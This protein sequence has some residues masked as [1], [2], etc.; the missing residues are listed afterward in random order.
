MPETPDP[1]F[2]LFVI[3]REKTELEH[4]MRSRIQGM[5]DSGMI[6][7]ARLLRERYPESRVLRSVG[8]AQVLDHL[9]GIRPAGRKIAPGLPGLVEEILLAHRQLAKTQRTWFKN[10]KPEQEFILDRDHVLLKERLM[11]IYQ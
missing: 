10:Q 5:L 8:Y 7:E 2:P 3:D 4:R 1:E 6:E 11:A 9:D